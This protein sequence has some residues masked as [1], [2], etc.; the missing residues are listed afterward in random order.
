MNRL[1]INDKELPCIAVADH[2]KEVYFTVNGN[3]DE[4]IEACVDKATIKVMFGEEEKDY[5]DFEIL[6]GIM[7]DK[8]S[9]INVVYRKMTDLEKLIELHYGGVN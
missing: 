3:I 9:I 4:V 1:I 6:L 8:T 5:S 2:G 7:Y